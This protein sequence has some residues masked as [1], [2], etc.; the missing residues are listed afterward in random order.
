MFFY[1]ENK[2]TF[3]GPADMEAYALSQC[4]VSPPQ[5][6]RRMEEETGGKT[7]DAGQS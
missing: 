2:T 3:M 7:E 6:Q 5:A 1:K 4:T